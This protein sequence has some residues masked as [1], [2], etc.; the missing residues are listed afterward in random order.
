MGFHGR[1]DELAALEDNWNAQGARFHVLWGRRRVGKT[2]LLGRFVQGRRA[3]YF[4]ATDAARLDQLRDLSHEL[5]RVSG[6]DLLVRQPP[7]SW[8]AAL[9]AVE[10]YA[11]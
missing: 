1:T 4:E 3:L 11:A 10:Q 7:T 5:A 9:A 6:D 8:E 2:E